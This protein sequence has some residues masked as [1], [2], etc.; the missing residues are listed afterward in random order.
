MSCLGMPQAALFLNF[1]SSTNK[2][3]IVNH[4]YAPLHLL[5]LHIGLLPNTHESTCS[6]PISTF[7]NSHLS[8]MMSPTLLSKKRNPYGLHSVDRARGRCC[9]WYEGSFKFVL[10]SLILSTLP[11]RRRNP[12]RLL[13][14][15]IPVGYLM[16]FLADLRVFIIFYV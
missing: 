14:W 5:L 12:Y 13:L 3:S 4:A 1:N 10:F 7:F 8:T 6:A 11:F 2:H 15:F 9:L 16:F